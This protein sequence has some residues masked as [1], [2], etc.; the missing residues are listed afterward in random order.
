MSFQ[1]HLVQFQGPSARP[2]FPLDQAPA[3]EGLL[4]N[5][6][7]Q[8]PT[9]AAGWDVYVYGAFVYGVFVDWLEAPVAGAE[10]DEMAWLV[11]HA[12]ELGQ[13]KGEWLL[14]RG[15]QLLV[16]SR[17]FATIQAA[18]RDQRLLGPFVYY[19]PTDEESNSVTI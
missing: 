4:G 19:V 11:Q 16:H 6:L 1:E 12:E 8:V 10:S 17:D 3:V 15:Q 5:N 14:I 13:H 9:S 7:A 18:I 2:P